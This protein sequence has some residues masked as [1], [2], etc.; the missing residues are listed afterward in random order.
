M[1]DTPRI[2]Y[3]PNPNTTADREAEIL[4]TIYAFIL[5]C[6]AKRKADEDTEA[7]VLLHRDGRSPCGVDD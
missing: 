4:A 5:E 3:G 6:Q 1:S 2:T 7:R